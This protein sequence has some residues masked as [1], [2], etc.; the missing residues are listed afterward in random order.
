MAFMFETCYQVKITKW[1]FENL[2]DAS[3]IEDSW[4]KLPKKFNPEQK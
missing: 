2:N 1:A 4:T 3:Y